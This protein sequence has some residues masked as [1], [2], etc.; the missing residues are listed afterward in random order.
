MG[1]GV[2]GVVATR[3]VGV[4]YNEPSRTLL[5]HGKRATGT[6]RE[7]CCLFS[8]GLDETQYKHVFGP[9]D[10]TDVWSVVLASKV[11]LAFLY[12]VCVSPD[13][14][15]DASAHWDR[16]QRLDL[17]TGTSSVA[18]D[19]VSFSKR[20]R[21]PGDPEGIYGAWVSDIH[22][23]SDDG[24]KLLCRVAKPRHDPTPTSPNR[25]HIDY[26]L[27]QLDLATGDFERLTL[28]RNHYF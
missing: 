2:D 13:A 21:R 18:L 3:I 12:V 15:P 6:K 19:A 7:A 20:H 23:A 22:S 16:I 8:R 11:P 26:F 24:T 17:L 1:W 9:D 27:C 5:V 4:H 10:W 14:R 28:L 25:V